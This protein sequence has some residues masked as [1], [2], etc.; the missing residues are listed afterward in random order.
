AA[1]RGAAGH[2]GA[3]AV[4]SAGSSPRRGRASGGVDGVLP[5]TRGPRA[6]LGVLKGRPVGS[7]PRPSV[8]LL[9]VLLATA[10]D[11]A[12][13][14]TQPIPSAGPSPAL[15]IILGVQFIDDKNNTLFQSAQADL[16]F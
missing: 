13:T 9:F 4:W 11:F 16:A 15:R 8:V 2:L 10:C 1:A 7:L 5:Q 3:A 6:H 14:V 12:K